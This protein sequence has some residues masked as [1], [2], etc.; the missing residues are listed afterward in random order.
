MY[1]TAQS[2]TKDE[3]NAEYKTLCKK[4][5]PDVKGGSESEFK[6]MKAQYDKIKSEMINGVWKKRVEVHFSKMEIKTQNH[7]TNKKETYNVTPEDI[8]KAAEILSQ[9]FNLFNKK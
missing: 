6:L 8:Q 1:F 2:Y 3:L 4:L 7:H 9:F 5:H